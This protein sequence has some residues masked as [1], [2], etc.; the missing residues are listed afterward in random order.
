MVLSLAA[1]FYLSAASGFAASLTW[2]TPTIISSDTDVITSGSLVY[3]HTG[4]TNGATVNGVAFTAGNS[5]TAWGGNV[6]LSGFG[7]PYSAYGGTNAPWTNLSAAYQTVLQGGAYGGATTG[8]VTLK[9]LTAG[10]SYS[11]QI[12]VNDARSTGAGRSATATGANTVT[13]DYNNINASGGVGQYVIGSFVA[14]STN[15]TFTLTSSSSVQLNAINLRDNGV[16]VF[17]PTRVN[18]AKYQPV[19]VDS[20]NGSLTSALI[21]NVL[22]TDGLVTDTSSWQ[23]DNTGPHWAEVDFPFPVTVGSAQLVMGLDNVSPPTGFLLQYLTNGIW[24]NVP[25]TTVSGNTNKER[26]IVFSSSV[27]ATA[28]RFYDSADATVRLRELALY[29]PN[30]PSGFPFGTDFLIDLARKQPA[31]ATANT[32]GGWPLLAAD[33]MVDPS[34]AWQTTLVGSNALQLNLQFTNKIGS[35]HLYSGLAGVSPLSDFVLQYWTGSAWQ[36]I[37]GGSVTGNTSAALVIPFTSPVTTTKVQ[38]VFTNTGISAVQELCVFPANNSS[39]YLLGTG[40]VSNTPV[41][42]DYDTYSDSYYYLSN[43]ASGLVVV[44]SNA[45]PVLGPPGIT[46]LATQ[47]QVLLNYDTGTYRLRNRA[48]GL[49]LSGAQMTTNAG[50]ALVD[51]TYSALPDQDWYLQSIDGTNFYVVNQFSGLV[52]D[53]QGGVLVQNVQT[54]SST[55]LLQISLAKIFPKK[56]IAGSWGGYP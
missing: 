33:G 8:T 50:T 39:G 43:S 28:F 13:L 29:P 11:A 32:F 56:G 7:S 52:L 55:Q 17:S 20:T 44:E 41:A 30:G 51:E 25:G 34:T 35:A 22:V 4:G 54:N 48:T 12:W 36:N 23:S 3:A 47:Y 10:H 53:T 31:F 9:G 5:G 37:P 27:K 42:A 1:G 46:N 6:S 15:Q 19:I 16:Y 40:I 18:L 14:N 45:V 38:L 21:T 2:G 24:T 49:H 26:N